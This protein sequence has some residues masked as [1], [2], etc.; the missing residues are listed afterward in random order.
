MIK[1]LIRRIALWQRYFPS[2]K[3]RA[4]AL[5][6]AEELAAANL[7]V[8]Q[9]ILK[10]CLQSRLSADRQLGSQQPG[11]PS[12]P[13]QLASGDSSSNH[14]K[15]LIENYSNRAYY[16]VSR[17]DVIGRLNQTFHRSGIPERED[18]NA[19]GSN[20]SGKNSLTARNTAHSAASKAIDSVAIDPLAID[21]RV[22]DHTVTSYTD[23]PD[24]VNGLAD[25]A[26][27][28][29]CQGR[30]GE[31]EQLYK[32]V[33]ELKQRRLGTDHLDVAVN[34][35]DLAKLYCLQHRY[36]E[37]QPLFE[38]ALS[39]R[40]NYLFAYNPEIGDTLYQL[41]KVHCHQAQ[42]GKAEPLFQQAL[43]IFRQ[44][45]GPRH[46]RAQA[47]YTDLMKM[48]VMVIEGDKFAEL[49]AELPPLDLN[50]LSEIY[51]WAKPSWQR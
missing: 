34:L 41:A 27:L 31:A 5:P 26:S 39:I 13:S 44:Q 50:N 23:H 6:P 32:Q 38:Q 4:Q 25:A 46:P 45:F 28:C 48:I 16:S 8:P 18:S 37:A 36:H 3:R 24:V 7:T 35:S 1:Q 15:Y 22:I 21:H 11:K 12:Q 40:Q 2:S 19:S 47:V 30:Y 17:A 33:I 14:Q 42:Y 9:A 43:T 49:S 29:E 20:A 51:S 10:G